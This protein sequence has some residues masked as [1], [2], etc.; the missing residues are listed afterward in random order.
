MNQFEIGDEVRSALQQRERDVE[1]FL[2]GQAATAR[3]RPATATGRPASR[4]RFGGLRVP[5]G[6]LP[7]AVTGHQR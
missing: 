2:A 6:W 3:N 1:L 7:R 4:P 5:T